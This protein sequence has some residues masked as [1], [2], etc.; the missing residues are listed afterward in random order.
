[1]KMKDRELDVVAASNL[2]DAIPKLKEGW[3]TVVTLHNE[4]NRKALIEN[5]KSFAAHP[6]LTVYFVNPLVA[7]ENK[8]VIVPHTHDK[9]CDHESL[10][11]GI[12]AM[13][14]LVPLVSAEEVGRAA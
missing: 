6:K 2:K 13:G 1:M 8:W 4:A 7:S 12:T 14:E 9:V 10:A 3:L 5:W 11:L